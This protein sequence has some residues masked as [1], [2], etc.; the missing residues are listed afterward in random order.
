MRILGQTT[1]AKAKI[2]TRVARSRDTVR[3][4]ATA[5][6]CVSWQ[7]EFRAKRLPGKLATLNHD[8]GSRSQTPGIVVAL[9]LLATCRECSRLQRNAKG[10]RQEAEHEGPGRRQ[11]Q[12][13]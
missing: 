12:R 6:E 11:A 5:F 13:N 10:R 2:E 8:A 7:P 3:H 4:R 1:D 9:P